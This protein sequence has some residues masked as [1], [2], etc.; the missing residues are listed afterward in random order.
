MRRI[1]VTPYPYLIFYEP[2]EDEII[3]I[4][5]RHNARAPATMPGQ[6]ETSS[7]Q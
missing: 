3:F 4:G 1:V 7:P 5:I 2:A 6:N